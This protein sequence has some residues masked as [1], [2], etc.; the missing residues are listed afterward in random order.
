MRMPA[1]VAALLLFVA[2]VAPASALA[3]GAGAGAGA[4]A[5]GAVAS[6]V[7][8]AAD[9]PAAL[10]GSAVRAQVD[11]ETPP[12]TTVEI[13]LQPD[14]SARWRI[15]THFA[16][17]S[18]NETEAFR[19]IAERYEAGEADAGPDATL[20]RSLNRRASEATGREMA[21]RNVTYHGSLDEAAGRGT[22][23]LTFQ[24]TN[25]L[26][27][28][29]NETLVLDDVFRLPTAESDERRTWLSVFDAD[30]E[31]LIRPPDGYTVTGTSIAV[32]QQESAIVL[33][34]PSDF[35]GERELRVTYRTVGPAEQLPIGV[36]AGGG[37]ILLAALL[38]AAWLLRGRDDLPGGASTTVSNGDSG[39]PASSNGAA[40]GDESLAEGSAGGTEAA[41]T[42]GGSAPDDAPDTGGGAASGIDPSLLSDEE[43]V[44]RL[45]SQNNGRM[46]QATI[47]DETGWSDAKVS[48]LLST[49]A[50]EGRINKLRLGRENVISLP[51]EAAD[52]ESDSGQ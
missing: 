26:R 10:D 19:T 17:D 6:P 29:D 42:V 20:F 40:E 35:E 23:A 22:L 25:F 8:P 33:A 47:V 18:E 13:S 41:A 1:L 34:E 7:F 30:Q 44:E 32:Q 51:E 28:G 5:D 2:A 11:E 21:I 38:G 52:D 45:L 31:I 15:E 46:K 48:Q 14:R 37:L 43:R 27:R 4:A 16:L 24:W 12:R 36:L 9:G 3:V 50:E 39:T 49:M